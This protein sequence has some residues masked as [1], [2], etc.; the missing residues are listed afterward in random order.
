MDQTDGGYTSLFCLAPEAI[1]V[2]Y[3]IGVGVC[4]PGNAV[5]F[6]PEQFVMHRLGQ[7][8]YLGV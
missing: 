2:L 7:L 4:G 1:S 3:Y 8:G 5:A 6:D